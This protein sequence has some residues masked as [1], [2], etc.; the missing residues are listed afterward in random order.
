MMKSTQWMG[1]CAIAISSATAL[2]GCSSEPDPG[3]MNTAGTSTGGGASGGSGGGSTGTQL[4]SPLYHVK[5]TGADAAAGMPAPA[6]Y[7]SAGCSACHGANAEGT[8]IGPEIRFTP[9][10]YAVGVVRNGRKTPAGTPSAMVAVST[11]TLSDAD[12]DLINTWQ[13][14][15]TK[16]TTG[17]GLY[18]AMCGNC[19]GPTTPTGGSAPISIQGKSK[20]E[21]AMYVRM[22]AGTDLSM[23]ATYMPKFDMTLLNETELGLIQGHLGSM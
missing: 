17:P 9:K 16:P 12:L 20:V 7:T 1:V 18:L 13:N 15:F 14:S 11:T 21:V 23:R 8:T 5:L 6:V 2:S 4:Q 19:H 3:P 22:G 10:D